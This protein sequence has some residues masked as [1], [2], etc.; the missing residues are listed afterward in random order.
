MKSDAPQVPP[1]D[2]VEP[3]PILTRLGGSLGIAASLIALALFFAACAGF[4]GAFTLSMLPVVLGAVG[5]SIS[6]VGGVVEMRR[7]VE[8]T[9]VLAAIFTSV[10]GL[11]AGTAEMAVWLNWG[12]LSK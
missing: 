8:D 12:T 5:L 7:M 2:P 1:A 3:R 6:I 4:D 9:H 10:L 11:L